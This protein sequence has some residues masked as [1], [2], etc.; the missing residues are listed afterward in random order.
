M[1]PGQHH[2]AVDAVEPE[3]GVQ[4][5]AIGLFRLRIRPHEQPLAGGNRPSAGE[6]PLP[7]VPRIVAEIAAARSTASRRR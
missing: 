6:R 1:L 5:G 3:G 7:H 2:G 4:V